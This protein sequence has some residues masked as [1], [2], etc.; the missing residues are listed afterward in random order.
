MHGAVITKVVGRLEKILNAD[1]DLQ[2]WSIVR[3][4]SSVTVVRTYRGGSTLTTQISTAD[5]EVI[6]ASL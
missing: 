1:D 4:S 5:P 2:A 6:N 3:T